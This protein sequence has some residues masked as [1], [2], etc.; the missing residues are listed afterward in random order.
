MGNG[1]LLS[2]LA[3][4]FLNLLTWWYVGVI[5][6]WWRLLIKVFLSNNTTKANWGI[7]NPSL[8]VVVI[9][10]PM[11]PHQNDLQI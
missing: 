7:V 8:I 9:M 2:S 4:D 1:A 3:E 6:H 11:R 5:P 10:L